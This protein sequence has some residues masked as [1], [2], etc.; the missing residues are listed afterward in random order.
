MCYGVV[1][2]FPTLIDYPKNEARD[3]ILNLATPIRDGLISINNGS[4]KVL[5]KGE[6][7]LKQLCSYF[8]YRLNSQTQ[9]SLPS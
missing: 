6:P 5:S 2:I 8:D 3:I 1:D 4:L 7:F 9:Q